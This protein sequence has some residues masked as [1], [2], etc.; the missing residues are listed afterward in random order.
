VGIEAAPQ[1]QSHSTFFYLPRASEITGHKYWVKPDEKRLAVFSQTLKAI[2]DAIHRAIGNN[3][4]TTEFAEKD[5][6]GELN[7]MTEEIRAMREE[8]K[9]NIPTPEA[10]LTEIHRLLSKALIQL[11]T[12]ANLQPDP[13]IPPD[14]RYWDQYQECYR[15]CAEWLY[16]ARIKIGIIGRDTL[17]NSGT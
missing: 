15:E 1:P 8:R 10:T 17:S 13:T 4:F 12:A 7:Y 11:N 9:V 14:K 3:T 5:L 16:A 2:E 6:R